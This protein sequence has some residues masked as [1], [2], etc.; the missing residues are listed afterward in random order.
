MRKWRKES[1]KE[2]AK[3]TSQIKKAHKIHKS[4]YAS[5][6]PIERAWVKQYCDFIFTARN[7]KSTCKVDELQ[8]WSQRRFLF[9]GRKLHDQPW[10]HLIK[11]RQIAP[12]KVRNVW[13]YKD[14]VFLQLVM[15]GCKL[16]IHIKKG[17]KHWRTHGSLWTEINLEESSW[18]PW[19]CKEIQ[20]VRYKDGHQVFKFRK[21]WC[22]GWN[23]VLHLTLMKSPEI[24]AKSHWC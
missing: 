20:P 12:T 1:E 17:S 9:C 15:Y 8:Q 2:G 22:S 4:G 23:C 24:N 7:T 10:R 13:S 14:I 5:W 16:K 19:I 21:D 3:G 6:K 11:Q 18:S